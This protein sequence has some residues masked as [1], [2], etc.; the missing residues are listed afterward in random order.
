MMGGVVDSRWRTMAAVLTTEKSIEAKPRSSARTEAEWARAH[1]HVSG[2][3]GIA[4]HVYDQ[5]EI[6]GTLNIGQHY[7][8]GYE[9]DV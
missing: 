5:L 7:F 4:F 8:Y 9:L 2:A 1:N 6:E 3:S